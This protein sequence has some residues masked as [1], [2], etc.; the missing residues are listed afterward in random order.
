MYSVFAAAGRHTLVAIALVG[1][2]VSV[3]ATADAATLTPE[4]Q[5]IVDKY[6]ISAADQEKL[7]GP[8]AAAAQAAQS[9]AAYVEEQAPEVSSNP[10]IR[11]LSGTYV[12][13]AIDTYKSIG[14]RITN[15]NGG[16]GAL[17]GSMG[18]VAG[19]NSGFEFGSS[20]IGIQ[21]G[22]SYGIYDPKGRLRLIPDDRSEETQLFYTAGVFKRSDMAAV[23]PTILDRISAGIVYDGFHAENWGVNGNDIELSQARGS[24]GFAITPST[25]IGVWGTIALDTDQAAITVAGAPGVR[26]TI[27]AMN[28]ANGYVKHNFDFG[29]E[30]MA[31]YGVL[32]EADIGEWQF[33]LAARAPLSDNWSAIASANYVNP[34]TPKGP[35]GSGQEQFSASVGLAY[36]FG[37]NAAASTVSGNSNLPLLD[38]A[39]QRSFLIT[40]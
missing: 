28:Q 37:G 17:T 16:T 31:Y 27:R 13:G 3:I 29:G 19:I 40:D 32:N 23:D 12:F 2:T 9:K 7:F 5:V 11:A 6:K 8:K 34:Q 10:V 39:S 38:V 4:Q 21:G 33:G 35:L 1:A 20:N 26:S 36:N 24:L 30:V 18:G 15:I 25:E 22:A 14:E